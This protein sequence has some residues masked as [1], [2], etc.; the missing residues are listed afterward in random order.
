[1]YGFNLV[2]L[3]SEFPIT[4]T[5]SLLFIIFEAELSTFEADSTFELNWE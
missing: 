1:M 4:H 2:Y 5:G 3:V